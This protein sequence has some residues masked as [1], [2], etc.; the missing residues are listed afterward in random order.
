MWLVENLEKGGVI[1]MNDV[2]MNQ[3]VMIC[4]CT[5]TQVVIKGKCNVVSID[6][7]SKVDVVVEKV[8]STIETTNCKKIKIQVG[9]ACPSV[10]VDKTDGCH[11]YLMTD[12]A[13]TCQILTSK[14]SD[15]QVSYV[16]GEDMKEVP[17]PE[18]FVH[19]LNDAGALKSRVSDLYSG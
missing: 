16:D 7:C 12:E 13:K 17:V 4:K 9:Q 1:E 14:H 18:Q 19:S 5:E 10:A 15:V 11:I 6:G 2:K 3:V 8:I